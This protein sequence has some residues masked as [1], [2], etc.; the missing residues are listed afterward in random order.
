MNKVM[1]NRRKAHKIFRNKKS[2][3]VKNVVE[4]IKEDQKHNSTKKMY[5]TINQFKKG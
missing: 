2:V 3:C 5:Q 4:S 1:K